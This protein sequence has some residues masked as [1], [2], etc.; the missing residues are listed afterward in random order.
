MKNDSLIMPGGALKACG[1]IEVKGKD[2]VSK[3]MGKVQAYGILHGDA[4][5][6]D[7]VGD[8]FTKG[9]YLGP[10]EGDG[11]ECLMHH[12]LPIKGFEDKRDHRFTPWKKVQR[13]ECG[14]LV[15]TLLDMADDYER[16]VYGTVMAGKMGVSSG[17]VGHTVRRAGDTPAHINEYGEIKTW[18]IGEISFT[19]TPC[20][21]RTKE[22]VQAIKALPLKALVE[23]YEGIFDVPQAIADQLERLRSEVNYQY[24]RS[25]EV[26]GRMNLQRR[27]TSLQIEALQ[28]LDVAS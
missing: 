2:G 8:W 13:D 28:L 15:E 20:E 21:P 18:V 9:T 17:A 5:K 26:E 27:L 22:H 12:T 3:Q 23:T 10:H 14:L 11:V 19:P 4:T 16:A 25:L 1:F 7:L 24:D 6:P